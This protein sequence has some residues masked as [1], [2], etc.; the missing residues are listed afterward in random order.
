MLG[1]PLDRVAL[2]PAA[3][4]AALGFVSVLALA[5]VDGG[6]FPRSWPWATTGLAA[7]AAIALLLRTRVEISGAG[8]ALLAAFG[9]FVALVQL[10]AL[11]AEDSVAASLETERALVYVAGALA[12]ATIVTRASAPYL[13]A[14]VLAGATALCVYSILDRTSSERP[15]VGPIGYANALG[16][17]AVL[18]ILVAAGLARWSR[19]LLVR[20]ALGLALVP[21]TGAL[22]LTESRG[23]V[24]ALAVGVG[25]ALALASLIR[26]F[27]A[28]LAVTGAVVLVAVAID[29]GRLVEGDRPH[30]W[31]VAVD[32]FEERPV[33]GSGAGSF[34]AYWQEHRPDPS[35][36]DTP[37]VL[38]AHSLY[39][40]T[41]A[42]LGLVGL[43]LILAAL[44]IPFVVGLRRRR[45]VGVAAG[46]PAYAAFVIHLG[47]DWD[48]EIPAVTL[49]GLFCGIAVVVAASAERSP[50]SPSL[51]RL[52]GLAI[53]LA[54]LASGLLHLI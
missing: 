47:L 23:S 8:V 11:W 30:Y 3:G 21:L 29:A 34:H 53:A 31:R 15:L 46:L 43:A 9:A 37:D 10:S 51:A 48:W 42:E 19:R 35:T 49:A 40:E 12:A 5:S 20:G 2:S 1:R 45:D 39:F 54:L 18:G 50:V 27:A 28:V 44:A 4:A 32:Q 41:L 25:V 24:V 17:V 6:F 33:L 14:G 52:L 36:L 26:L 22:V 16:V 7:A 13:L 38:D